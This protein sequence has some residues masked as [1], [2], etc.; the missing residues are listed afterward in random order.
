MVFFYKNTH[1][2]AP[3]KG[4]KLQTASNTHRITGGL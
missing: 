4:Q 3:T 1:K 2:S